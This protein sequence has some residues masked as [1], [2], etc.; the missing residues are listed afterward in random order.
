MTT[1]ATERFHL[2]V[3]N[4]RTKRETRITL[5]PLTKREAETNRSKFTPRADRTIELRPAD[6][7][8]PVAIAR[9]PVAVVISPPPPVQQVETVAA[10]PRKGL[11]GRMMD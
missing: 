6:V 10:G 5:L 9:E 4:T 7:S 11:S 3:V 8:C 2:V 1:E